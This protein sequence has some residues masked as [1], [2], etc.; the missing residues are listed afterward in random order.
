M[1]PMSGTGTDGTEDSGMAQSGMAG[2]RR[3]LLGLQVL[4]RFFGLFHITTAFS[5]ASEAKWTV[6]CAF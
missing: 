5:F 3:R 2:M 6:D 4:L 1:M